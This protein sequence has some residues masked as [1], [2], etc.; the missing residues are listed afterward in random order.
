[1]LGEQGEEQAAASAFLQLQVGRAS[2]SWDT[3]E[4]RR[5]EKADS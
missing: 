4:Q 2:Q 5:C 3:F 1:M